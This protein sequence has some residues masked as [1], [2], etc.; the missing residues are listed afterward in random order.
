[1]RPDSFFANGAVL[2]FNDA[3]Y[4]GLSVGVP[5]TVRGWQEALNSQTIFQAEFRFRTLS[6]DYRWYRARMVRSTKVSEHLGEPPV[7]GERHAGME[8]A[9]TNVI[10]LEFF[11]QLFTNANNGR[12]AA[13]VVMLMLAVVPVMIYQAAAKEPVK[14]DEPLCTSAMRLPSFVPCFIFESMLARNSIWPSLERV[15]SESSSP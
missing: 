14:S 7:P 4:S 12:A 1:M 2:P 8:T 5:G 15:T 11:N 6:G 10:G 3:R 9:N 13:I